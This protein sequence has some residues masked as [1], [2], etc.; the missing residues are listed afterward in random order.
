VRD[1]FGGGQPE[2]AGL[3]GRTL[4]DRPEATVLRLD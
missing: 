1:D 2:L 4:L 3:P